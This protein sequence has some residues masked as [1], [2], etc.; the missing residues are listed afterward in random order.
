[1]KKQRRLRKPNG[2]STAVRLKNGRN[3]LRR[4]R[5]SLN[6]GPTSF[7]RDTTKTKRPRIWWISIRESLKNSLWLQANGDT[8]LSKLAPI[9]LKD[10]PKSRTA[11]L[12]HLVPED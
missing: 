11:S 12:C 9:P 1:M 4:P 2:G 8:F 3:R 10:W 5:A 7:S 6:N